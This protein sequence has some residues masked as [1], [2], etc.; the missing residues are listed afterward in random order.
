MMAA[1]DQ[2]FR[3]DLPGIGRH[4]VTSMA[5]ERVDRCNAGLQQRKKGD[6]ELGEVWQLHQCGVTVAQPF[7]RQSCSQIGGQSVECVIGKGSFAAHD[8]RR[9]G[10]RLPL[11]IQNSGQWLIDPIGT[12]AVM[13]CQILW[14]A[15]KFDVHW[16][17]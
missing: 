15:L 12:G 13:R 3:I 9:G 14:P 6:V 4:L 7:C 2:K 17:T 10:T 11:L 1:G 5:V 16:K 8:R